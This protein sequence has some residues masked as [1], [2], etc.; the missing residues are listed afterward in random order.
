MKKLITLAFITTALLL[1]AIAIQAQNHPKRKYKSSSHNLQV[2]KLEVVQARQIQNVSWVTLPP[3]ARYKLILLIE[4][5][6]PINTSTLHS[7]RTFQLTLNGKNTLS[8][9]NFSNDKKRV[10]AYADKPALGPGQDLIVFVRIKGSYGAITDRQGRK[11]AFSGV[12]RV[13]QESD[14]GSSSSLK[15]RFRPKINQYLREDLLD[16]NFDGSPGGD[17]TKK[18]TIIG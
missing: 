4:F 13:P 10:I 14:S 16:G 7:G 17:Y 12:H 18:L 11:W 5:N 15:D 9:F 3:N 6:Y 8:S 2:E 1:S